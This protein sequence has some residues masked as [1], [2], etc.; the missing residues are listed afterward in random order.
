MNFQRNLI[1]AAALAIGFAAAA[2]VLANPE[3]TVT[4]TTTT[5]KHHYVYY[6]DHEIYFA[7]ETK[8]YYWR[9]DGT[10]ASGR[11]LPVE[12]R[13]YVTAGGVELELETDRP[14]DRH[15]WV[16]KHYRDHHDR[17]GKH[18][19]DDGDDKHDGDKH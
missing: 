3:S 7:P 9:H 19:R 17:D 8:T 12:S 1:A 2:P 11:E 14:Y 16:V 13:S 6:G 5:S 15:E 10:W 4:V 18:E